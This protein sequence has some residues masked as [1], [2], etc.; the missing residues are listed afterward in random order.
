MDYEIKNI[1][2]TENEINETIEQLNI[3]NN[4]QTNADYQNGL[5]I[6][7]LYSIDYI[8]YTKMQ[9]N[10][11]KVNSIDDRPF[12]HEKKAL[13]EIKQFKERYA[14]KIEYINN[15][16]QEIKEKNNTNDSKYEYMITDLYSNPP[17]QIYIKN[18]RGF[19]EKDKKLQ[20]LN[21]DD[22]FLLRH[23]RKP[24]RTFKKNYQNLFLD[25]NIDTQNYLIENEIDE[26]ITPLV[27]EYL[28]KYYK[29]KEKY[30]IVPYIKP[31]ST[32]GIGIIKKTPIADNKEIMDKLKILNETT[33]KIK[34]KYQL[35]DEMLKTK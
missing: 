23:V 15:I 2:E 28:I 33:K 12:F 34:S 20:E 35:E 1:N 25:D 11:F 18:D 24:D 29:L 27:K 21:E 5:K 14:K 13:E 17:K 6:F 26:R 9:N 7:I 19:W 22:Y 16:I 8:I 32:R 4:M 30:G 31:A 3:L 10:Q